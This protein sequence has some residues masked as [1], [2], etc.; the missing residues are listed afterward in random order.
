MNNRKCFIVLNKI[1]GRFFLFQLLL[2]EKLKEIK[3]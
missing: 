1:F 3:G 2:R